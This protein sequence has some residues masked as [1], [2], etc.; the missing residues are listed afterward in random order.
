MLD[1]QH[2]TKQFG[3]LTAVNDITFNIPKGEILGLIGPNGAGKT[4][5]INVITGITPMTGGQVAFNGR[6][7]TN[8]PA[9]ALCQIGIARTYQNIRLFSEMRVFGNVLTA[10]HLKTPRESRLWRW[11]LPWPDPATNAQEAISRQLLTRLNIAHLAERFATELSYGD[12]RRVELAR[13]LAAEPQLLFLDEPSAGMNQ[14]ETHQLG[15]LLL[16]LR[17]EGLTMLIIE[18]DMNL[19]NQVCDR[20]LVLNFGSLIAAGTPREVRT[21]PAVIEAYL[22]NE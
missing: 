3:G 11:L 4:T 17:D 13:A 16:Q 9:H 12:Q 22:G 1:V 15:E 19:I 21:N 10:R 7:I 14:T 18:H 8:W 20:V 5:L 6:S 2:L